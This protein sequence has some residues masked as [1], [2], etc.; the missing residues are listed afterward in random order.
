[1]AQETHKSTETHIFAH[2]KISLRHYTGNHN[3]WSKD[4]KDINVK[5]K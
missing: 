1:M 5:W 3:L 2:T 4:L